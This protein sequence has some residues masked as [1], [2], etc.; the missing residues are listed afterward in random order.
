MSHSAAPRAESGP[1]RPDP[2]GT[3][4]VESLIDAGA[5]RLGWPLAPGRAAQL[6]ASAAPTLAHFARV[7]AR[8]DFDSDPLAFL[9]VRDAFADPDQP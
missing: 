9:A 6:A 3:G 2:A 7:D 1:A 8:L 4:A 5:Q